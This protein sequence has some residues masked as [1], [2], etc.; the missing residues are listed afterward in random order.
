MVGGYLPG[1]GSNP[2]AEWS[3][4]GEGAGATLKLTWSTPVYVSQVIFYDRLN[5]DDQV[6]AGKLLFSDG[7]TVAVGTLAN[8]GASTVINF[9]PRTVSNVLFTISQVSATTQNIGLAEIEFYGPYVSLS[10]AFPR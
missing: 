2:G 9:T 5:T 1:T 4:N 10:S 6:L 8:S 3:S 7:S